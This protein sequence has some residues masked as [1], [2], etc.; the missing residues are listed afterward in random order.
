MKHLKRFNEG[1]F[2]KV[3]SIFKSD[4]E[5]IVD[6]IRKILSGKKSIEEYDWGQPPNYLIRG[7]GWRFDIEINGRVIPGTRFEVKIV[8]FKE[9]FGIEFNKMPL[10]NVTFHSTELREYRYQRLKR[11][12]D[13]VIH[14]YIRFEK[15]KEE[16]ELDYPL[17][18]IKNWTY[19]IKDFDDIEE[20]KIE[21]LNY[22][23]DRPIEVDILNWKSE[24]GYLITFETRYFSREKLKKLWNVV[25]EVNK[26]L[27]NSGLSTSD[28][29]SLYWA[30]SKVLIKRK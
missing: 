9:R 30:K 14:E 29:L 5:L 11:I 25:R 22:G 23:D 26:M 28:D 21:S 8:D 19:D 20:F 2:S 13:W 15:E 3:K 4:Y 6:D 24:P 1:I 12:I 10:L 17:S 7:K 18:D 16:F 27:N